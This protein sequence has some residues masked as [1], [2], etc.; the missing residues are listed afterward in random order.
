MASAPSPGIAGS[1]PQRLQ[2]S[3]ARGQAGTITVEAAIAIPVAMLLF[4]AVLLVAVVAHAHNV[5]LAAAQDAARATAVVGGTP[6]VGRRRAHALLRT[7]LG[8]AADQA[9]I[10]IQ[11]ETTTRATVSLPLTAIFPVPA[12]LRL[13]VIDEQLTEPTSPAGS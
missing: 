12:D 5:L 11:R 9:V 10:H 6:E 8:A 4:V 3:G 7:G 13:Q 1:K 2:Q